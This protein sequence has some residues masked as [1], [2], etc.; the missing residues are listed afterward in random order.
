MEVKNTTKQT[1]HLPHGNVSLK[2]GINEVDKYSL[3]RNEGHPGYEQQLEQ[4]MIEIISDDP[5]EDDSEEDNL[6]EQ[7][8]DKKEKDEEPEYYRLTRNEFPRKRKKK[9]PFWELSNGKKV[10]GNENAYFAQKEIN[11]K[12][13]GDK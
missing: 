7:Q 6:N 11:E 8:I 1:I 4:G 10:R 5:V 3:E 2:P 12:K 13:E 9:S